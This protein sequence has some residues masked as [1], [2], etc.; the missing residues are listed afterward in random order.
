MSGDLG[1]G[2][3]CTVVSYITLGAKA[4]Y[5]AHR[6]GNMTCRWHVFGQLEILKYAVLRVTIQFFFFFFFSAGANYLD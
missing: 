1:I 6:S 5:L 2:H 4:Q 3:R